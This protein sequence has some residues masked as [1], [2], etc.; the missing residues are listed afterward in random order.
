MNKLVLFLLVLLAALPAAA[1]D[2]DLVPGTLTFEDLDRTYWLHVPD[3]LTDPA[4]LVLV[5]H[6]RFG[7]GPSIANHTGFNA[8]ADREGFIA[9]YPDGIDGEWNFVRGV[10]GYPNTHDD[11]AFLTELVDVI[12]AEYPVDRTRVYATG[13]SN[14]GFMAERIACEAPAPFAA[15]ATVAAA[16]FGG[17][18]NVCLEP[19]TAPAPIL[20]IHGTADDN[21][22]W[23]GMSV[24]RGDRTVYI[25]YPIPDTVGYWA[26]FNGCQPEAE[27]TDVPR[28]HLSPGTSVRI[29][30]IDCPPNASVVLY[31]VEGGGH[32][33]PNPTHQPY[34][35][36]GLINRD[37]DAAEEIWSFFDA[38]TLEAN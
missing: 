23:D 11:V 10:P 37:I 17:M 1:Q 18:L 12:A 13:F 5:L 22:P 7:D 36:S 6:G 16:G 2:N 32:N 15:F 25:T 30:T 9:A 8:I 20:L 3:D 38:H 19:E 35:G 33:W 26:G 29:L 31:I 21:I 14:G 4:P 27:T 34:P 24:T 28:S